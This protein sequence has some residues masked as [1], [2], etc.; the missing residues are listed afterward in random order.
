MVSKKKAAEHL[1]STCYA[2]VSMAGAFKMEEIMKRLTLILSLFA[3]LF[4][5]TG[6]WAA[7]PAAISANV[8]MIVAEIDGGKDVKTIEANAYDPYAFVLEE[9]GMLLVHPSLAGKSLKEAAPPAYEAIVVAT[10]EGTWV[11]YEWKGKEKNTYVK[12][13]K[14]NLIVGSGY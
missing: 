13:T 9:D 12:K 3:V 10:P 1:A 14:S 8:D 4:I 6:A 5:V 7:D 11:K 2:G